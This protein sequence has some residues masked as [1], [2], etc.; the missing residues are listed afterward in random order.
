MRVSEGGAD[1]LVGQAADDVD[2]GAMGLERGQPR[3]RA[4]ELTG[5]GR[6]PE[7]VVEGAVAD[8]QPLRP[9]QDDDE[10]E[11]HER[12]RAQIVVHM[13]LDRRDLASADGVAQVPVG[14]DLVGDEAGG[15]D[16]DDQRVDLQ[17]QSQQDA[18]ADLHQHEQVD[19][20]FLGAAGRL[21]ARGAVT[22]PVGDADGEPQ[23]QHDVEQVAGGNRGD[24]HPRAFRDMS[25]ETTTRR[26]A[27]F[28][29]WNGA[30]RTC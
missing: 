7:P 28:P 29:V 27:A 21:D 22:E 18:D 16:G 10:G 6:V 30:A 17:E 8:R 19:E 4:P 1:L 26:L 23:R 5:L 13:L 12:Q 15:H 2:V 9:V 11:G 14:G 25:R 3:R 20:G 24:V